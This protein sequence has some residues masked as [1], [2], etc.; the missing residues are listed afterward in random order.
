MEAGVISHGETAMA[1]E[2]VCRAIG[3]DLTATYPGYLWN[4]GCNHQSGVATICLMMP[5]PTP[6]NTMK[7]FQINLSTVLGPGGQKRVREAGGEVL[8]RWGLPRGRAPEDMVQRAHQHGLD[9]G[10]MITKSK[11]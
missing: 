9:T 8:E 11:Y 3:E 5:S 7:G 6:S 10:N 1:D 2:D 4:V